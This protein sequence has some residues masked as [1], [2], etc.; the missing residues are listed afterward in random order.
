MI[1]TDLQPLSMIE[2]AG[3]RGFMRTLNPGYSIPKEISTLRP[4]LVRLYQSVKE[5]VKASLRSVTDV[6]LTSE[7][8]TRGTEF[9]QTVSCHFINDTLDHLFNDALKGDAAD[10]ALLR[11]CEKMMKFL[12]HNSNS[13]GKLEEP[14]TPYQLTL[15]GETRWTST[16]YMLEKLSPQWNAINDALSRSDDKTLRLNDRELSKINNIVSALRLFEDATKEM[17][18]QKY[19]SLSCI[20][21][22]AGL[23]KEKLGKLAGNGNKVAERLAAKFANRFA[24]IENSYGL[25]A[26][27]TL[28]ARFRFSILSDHHSTDQKRRQG[29]LEE[30]LSLDKASQSTCTTPVSPDDCQGG[31]WDGFE[32]RTEC[33]EELRKY[34]ALETIPRSGNPLSWWRFHN[35]EFPNLQRAAR[36]YLGIVS[37][38][39]PVARTLSRAGDVFGLQRL[40]LQLE[41]IDMML[42]L[43]GNCIFPQNA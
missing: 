17:S 26:S 19:G 1:V 22:L 36:R 5:E 28:D 37:T 41:N 13:T 34:A 20:I 25:A 39:V 8:W 43:N 32:K 21:P 6:V 16:L 15:S 11:K 33:E 30:T 27:T 35:E 23:L 4:K 38:C 14:L 29:F 3:F 42:F 7:L 40:Q 31:L 12:H 9:Y 10:E 24:H 2:G 18:Q